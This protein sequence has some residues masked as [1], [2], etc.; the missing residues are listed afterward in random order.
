MNLV[1][2]VG[3][4][5]A[6]AAIFVDNRVIKRIENL[7]EK[8]LMNV[9]AQEK[10]NH[11]IF[12]SVNH[13]AEKLLSICTPPWITSSVSVFKLSYLLPLPIK[14]LYKTPATL[15]MDRV[16]AVTGATILY[17]NT[18]SLLIDAGTC[19]T[20]D[21]I[22]SHLQYHGGA[23]S[24]GLQM[25]FRAL[26]EFTAKLPLFSKSNYT[27][28]NSFIGES[29]QTSMVSGVINGIIHEIEGMID[30]FKEKFGNLQVIFCGGD[31]LFLYELVKDKLKNTALLL[32]YQQDALFIGLNRILQYNLE[33]R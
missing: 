25:R 4:T 3:N 6:K 2:D 18:N 17:P 9:L 28:E 22:D 7:D 1:I 29:T 21:Y 27:K 8:A 33:L 5:S 26:H 12:S 14:V 23:I 19:I 31:G 24:L 10:I 15:G 32:S 30:L 16:A 11:I 20:F 13:H